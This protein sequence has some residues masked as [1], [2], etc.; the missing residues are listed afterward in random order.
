MC[1]AAVPLPA[2][3]PTLLQDFKYML[4]LC[5]QM[6]ANISISFDQ[7]GT[8]L[9]VE[10]HFGGAQVGARV[11]ARPAALQHAGMA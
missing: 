3:L 2:A 7:P 9:L 1:T 10:P 11:L 8:P 4:T 6:N 5:G